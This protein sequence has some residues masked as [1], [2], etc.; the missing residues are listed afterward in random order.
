MECSETGVNNRMKSQGRLEA[1]ANTKHVAPPPS[2][3][4]LPP[5]AEDF[6][7]R[8]VGASREGVLEVAYNGRWGTVCEDVDW[9][10]DDAGVVCDELGL[11]TESINSIFP[12]GK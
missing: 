2:L 6:S 12:S 9:G 7:V 11:E 8:L 10:S 4:L 5:D 1:L 3:T